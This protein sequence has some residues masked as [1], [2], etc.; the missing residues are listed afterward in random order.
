M[1]K[2]REV[3][4][5]LISIAVMALLLIFNDNRL[6][7]E[8]TL[9]FLGVSSIIILTAVVSK[10]LIA[11]ELDVEIEYRLWKFQ[12]YWITSS[13]KLKKPIPMGLIFPLLIG[14]LSSG[15]LKMLTF[16]QFE[17]K[18]L[19][20]KVSKQYGRRR[21]S[22]LMEWDESL[23]VFWSMFIMLAISI[24]LT[25]VHTLFCNSLSVFM[26]YYVAWNLIPFG[27]LDG[28]KLL[29]G[30]HHLYTFTLVITAISGFLVLL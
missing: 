17:S 7:T 23:I 15:F 12:R 2:K 3:L 8:N 13:S 6:F 20:S 11:D 16:L 9:S 24:G 4:A 29:M 27:K 22:T 14:F 19:P 5:I 10:K 1:F 18:A 30:S 26:F 21:F 28:M 25:F